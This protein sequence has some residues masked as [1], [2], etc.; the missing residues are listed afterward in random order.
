MTLR[1]LQASQALRSLVLL[2]ME[3]MTQWGLFHASGHDQDDILRTN[4]IEEEDSSIIRRIECLDKDR[5]G[6]TGVRLKGSRVP[7]RLFGSPAG[8][9][10]EE[11]LISVQS[12]V[13]AYTGYTTIPGCTWPRMYRLAVLSCSNSLYDH[14]SPAMGPYLC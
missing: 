7:Q 6:E 13:P 10:A 3:T 9:N 1:I 14:P 12:G 11:R 8:G 2:S 5:S 4:R